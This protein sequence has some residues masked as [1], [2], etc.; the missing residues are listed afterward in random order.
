[1]TIAATIHCK[2]CYAVYAFFSDTLFTRGDRERN[3]DICGHGIAHW[4]GFRMPVIKFLRLEFPTSGHAVTQSEV[5]LNSAAHQVHGL[6][7]S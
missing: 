3:C 2:V 6:Q 7:Y 4:T 1:M 5:P